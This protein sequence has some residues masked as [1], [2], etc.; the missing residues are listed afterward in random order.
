MPDRRRRPEADRFLPLSPVAFDILLALTDGERHG[1]GIL[2]E[3]ALRGGA[4]LT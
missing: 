3:V 1:Y 2:R 4:A